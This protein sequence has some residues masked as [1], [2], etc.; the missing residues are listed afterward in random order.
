MEAPQ[1]SKPRGDDAARQTTLR[2]Y[3]DVF[4]GIGCFDGKFHIDI[5]PKVKP[6]V[7]PP[8]RVPFALRDPPKKELD[9]LADREILEPVSQP[10]DWVN[11]CVCVTKK[12][13]NIRLCLDPK[14]LNQAIKRPH[15]LTPTFDDVVSRLHGAKWFSIL[16]A[17]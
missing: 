11:S 9:S 13:G 4:Q 6:V 2:E 12:N 10:T 8:R 14:D 7:H 1:P 3:G 17:R 5:D 15:Y 16:D